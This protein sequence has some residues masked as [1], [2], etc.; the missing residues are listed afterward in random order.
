MTNIIISFLSS[1]LITFIVGHLIK[2]QN[3]KLVKIIKSNANKNTLSIKERSQQK[4]LEI[5]DKYSK[6]IDSI[7]E[8]IDLHLQTVES[9]ESRYQQ[10]IQRFQNINEKKENLDK[11]L[12]KLTKSRKENL[13]RLITDL[14]KQSQT[15]SSEAKNQI[16][17]ELESQTSACLSTN[18]NFY[19]E[20]QKKLANLLSQDI[21]KTSIQRITAESSVDKSNRILK[22]AS[23]NSFKKVMKF[24]NLIKVLSETLN[25]E[26]EPLERE[27][28]FRVSAFVMWNAEI[29]KKVISKI[30]LSMN[31]SEEKLQETIV[32]AQNEFKKHLIMIGK[33]AASKLGLQNQSDNL[34]EVIGKLNYRTSFGQNI[35]K[36]SFET[37]YLCSLIASQ[38]GADPKVALLGGFFHD[39]GKAL[40]QEVE[41]SH[42]VLGMEFLKEEGFPF[43]IYHP[44]HSHHNIVPIETIEGQIVVIG[45]KLSAARQGARTESL[46]MYLQRVQGLERIASES[47]LVS[48]SFAVSAG[49]EIRAYLNTHKS[50]D[51]DLQKVAKE[52][53]TKIEDELIYP[54]KIKV[55]IIREYQVS[56]IAK[57]K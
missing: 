40:D 20:R 33:K 10:R 21:L 22:L 50:N 13:T 7:K 44:A 54:G 55:N 18:L 32:K 37:G 16:I 35:L 4:L 27:N 9:L 43:E 30:A 3:V 36:H 28:S 29:A 34:Y 46:E 57:N 52:L 25:V 31:F 48:K 23:R 38:V 5:K 26:I 12:E 2:E 24:E 6:K 51:N 1:F 53:V 39:I 47:E 11:E 15:T 42:D 49:R 19:V 8:S 17:K 45:D 56:S 14:E 41:G